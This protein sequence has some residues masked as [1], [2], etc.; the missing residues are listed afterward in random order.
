MLHTNQATSGR[1]VYMLV[2]QRIPDIWLQGRR[3]IGRSR[4]EITGVP[5][6]GSVPGAVVQAV[7]GGGAAGKMAAC[8]VCIKAGSLVSAHSSS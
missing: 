4:E 3:I 7:A 2:V 1:N 8:Y 5:I 6:I